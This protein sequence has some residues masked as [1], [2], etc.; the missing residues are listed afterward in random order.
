[1][2]ELLYLGQVFFQYFLNHII[3][4]FQFIQKLYYEERKKERKLYFC[5]TH[6]FRQHLFSLIMTARYILLEILPLTFFRPSCEVAPIALQPYA[7]SQNA[8]VRANT[9]ARRRA[10]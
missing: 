1:M 8:F 5:I 10:Q 2:R 6:V 3:G 9:R 4:K 7:Y